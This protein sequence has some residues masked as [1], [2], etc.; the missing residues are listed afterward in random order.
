MSATFMV[1]FRITLYVR[2]NI[3]QRKGPHSVEEFYFL[4]YSLIFFERNFNNLRN[5]FSFNQN[6]ISLKLLN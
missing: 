2:H 6:R 3:T 5:Y 4:Y 1:V